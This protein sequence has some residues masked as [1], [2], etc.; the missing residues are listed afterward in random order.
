METHLLTDPEDLDRRLQLLAETSALPPPQ[1]EVLPPPAE[2]IIAPIFTIQ[3]VIDPALPPDTVLP[4]ILRQTPAMVAAEIAAPCVMESVLVNAVDV[5]DE[6]D[7]EEG[8][9][10]GSDLDSGGRDSRGGGDV[11]TVDLLNKVRVGILM[12]MT[13]LKNR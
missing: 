6:A 2:G 1:I 4:V 5:D 7:S 9:G 10:G 13:Y 11:S 8:R 12:D 3:G